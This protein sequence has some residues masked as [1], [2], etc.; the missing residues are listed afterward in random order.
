MASVI[1]ENLRLYG[2]TPG[3]AFFLLLPEVCPARGAFLAVT[4]PCLSD[5]V[6][7][8]RLSA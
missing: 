2:L 1:L 6:F 8:S 4:A 5:V 3:G 7:P